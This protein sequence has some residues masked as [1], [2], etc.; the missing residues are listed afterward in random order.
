MRMHAVFQGEVVTDKCDDYLQRLL[1][2][3]Y[4]YEAAAFDCTNKLFFRGSDFRLWSI[5]V[6]YIIVTLTTC[7]LST[8]DYMHG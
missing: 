2:E 8:T 4:D 7:A 3:G 6:Y 5:S 1:D